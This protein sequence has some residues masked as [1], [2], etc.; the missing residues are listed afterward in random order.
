M[1]AAENNCLELI[2]IILEEE[3]DYIDVNKKNNENK[4]ALD[5]AEK[6][7]YSEIIKLLK[8]N[9][10]GN[11]RISLNSAIKNNELDRVKKLVPKK[12]DINS[13][14]SEGNTPLIAAVKYENIKTLKYLILKGAK[15]NFSNNN[16]K[17]P[18]MF[19]SMNGNIEIIKLLIDKGS[20][21]NAAD[22]NGYT[23]LIHASKYQNKNIVELFI[24]RKAKLNHKTKDGYT[25]IDIAI[26][27]ENQL[28]A[29]Y[30]DSSFAQGIDHP[31]KDIINILEDA[32]VKQTISRE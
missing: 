7:N 3:K 31:I 20:D 15:V 10:A 25:A 14:S 8:E 12:I 21:I 17:T 24:E 23:S 2:E 28:N 22:K 6:N 1:Y 27:T 4:T 26:L 9:G 5:I 13:V 19:A 18:L 11:L 30:N 16:G 29:M 32:G